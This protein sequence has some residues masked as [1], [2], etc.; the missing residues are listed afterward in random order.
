MTVVSAETWRAGIRRTYIVG[1]AQRAD[2]LRMNVG[3]L[4][5]AVE[6]HT[7]CLVDRTDELQPGEDRRG[8]DEC[9]FKVAVARH[10]LRLEVLGIGDIPEEAH[11]HPVVV[12]DVFELKSFE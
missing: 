3:R 1:G 8:I 11:V 2:N 12:R 6:E 4:D 7:Q 9:V 10:E 5:V